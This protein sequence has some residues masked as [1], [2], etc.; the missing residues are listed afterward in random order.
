MRCR[1]LVLLLALA[2]SVA[3]QERAIPESELTRPPSAARIAAL[4][5]AT[6][7][8]GWGRWT[9]PLRAAALRA[10]ET[11]SGEARAWY[12]LYRWSDLL[13]TPARGAINQWIQAVNEARVGHANMAASYDAGPG[14]LSAKVTP[15]LLTYALGTPEFSAE[16]FS[17]LTP[18][19][20]PVRVLEILQTLHADNAAT[21]AEFRSLALA[22][23][24]VFDVP[25]PPQWPHGQVGAA[26]LARNWPAPGEAFRYWV[27]LERTNTAA[28]RLRRLPASE[29]KHVVDTV[30]P[31]AELDWARK[32]VSPP[33]SDLAKAYDMIRYRKDR[34]EGNVFSWPRP[35]YELATILADGGICVDQAYF[36]TNVGKARGV[37]TL[38]F[39]GAGL[40]GRH[41]WFG[42]LS[43]SGWVLDAGRYAE[44]KYVA[45]IIL[46][47]QTW[48][49]I[50]D[51][52][53]L[54]LSERFRA[55]P[56]Y[57]QSELHAA[58]ARE[59]LRRRNLPAA[60]TAA[61]EAVNRDRR[62]LEAWEI[63]LQVQA[64][65]GTDAR[66][67]EGT[68]TEAAFALQKYP[69]LEIGFLRQRID[70][71]RQRGETSVADH[72]EKILANKYKSGRSDLA[73]Q[74]AAEIVA[75]S[76]AQDDLAT[77]MRV[78]QNV[79]RTHGAGAGVEFFDKV[80]VLFVDHLRRRR[81]VPAALQMLERARRTLKVEA[82]RQLDLEFRSLEA[83]LRQG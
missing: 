3:A 30:T 64:A 56:T 80:V 25:P 11:N 46:D 74:Q 40:D 13:A 29:L 33:L 41:A 52:E 6:G 45:G 38:F 75:R 78:Y 53:L 70:S 23:A 59:Y 36:A 15:A 54:F 81:E 5:Q 82:G 34:L 67:R 47:P 42:F 10:Y 55:L 76:M 50:S 26:A 65:A 49:P 14:S 19:D 48:K 62:N 32:N 71:L 79:L 18:V 16:F 60:L 37:P 58:F 68:L 69:D 83:A 31:F 12:A 27:R 28:H 61:R 35:T 44:Q 20:N 43:P 2:A 24:V 77:Q 4:V 39:S 73:V 66:T 8:E 17:L 72:E 51:H 21:F 9:E 57:G 63:L 22:I 1:V 7:T